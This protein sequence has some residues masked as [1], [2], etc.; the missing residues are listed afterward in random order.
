MAWPPCVRQQRKLWLSSVALRGTLPL[1]SSKASPTITL[2][3]F[4]ALVSSFMW[5][6][7]VDQLFAPKIH[8][9]F[10]EWTVTASLT[11]PTST[12][13]VY[14][15]KFSLLF[16]KWS[17]KSLVKESRQP[18]HFLTI[19]SP[20]TFRRAIR[21]RVREI[22]A[23]SCSWSTRTKTVLTIFSRKCLCRS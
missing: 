10:S 12:G 14:R 17:L 18:R 22:I 20:Q 15:R 6:W 11:S 4:S 16:A 13:W 3:T 9:R 1:K 19:F 5:C 2:P 7:Q 23:T 8:A 21:G